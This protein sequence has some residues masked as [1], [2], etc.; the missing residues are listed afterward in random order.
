MFFKGRAVA[1]P[2]NGTALEQFVCD[3]ALDSS[4]LPGSG[5]PAPPDTVTTPRIMNPDP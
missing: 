4:Q 5:P 3:D 1:A 2:F